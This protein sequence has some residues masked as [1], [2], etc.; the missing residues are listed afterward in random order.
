MCNKADE[1]FRHEVHRHPIVPATLVVLGQ[2]SSG[3][4]RTAYTVPGRCGRVTAFMGCASSKEDIKSEQIESHDSDWPMALLTALENTT[5]VDAL[6][7]ADLAKNNGVLPRCQDLPEEA[8]V[9]LAQMKQWTDSNTLPLLVISWSVNGLEPLPLALKPCV[10]ASPAFQLR[11]RVRIS[12]RQPMAR[13]APPG[14]PRRTAPSHRLR[15][16]RL[17]P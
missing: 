6:W 5:L 9:S 15:P 7:L 12:F 16:S 3:R 8:K 10:C 2:S 14:Y 4:H 11:A 1:T 17:W 13:S